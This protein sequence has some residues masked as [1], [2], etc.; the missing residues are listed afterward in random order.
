MVCLDLPSCYKYMTKQKETKKQTKK[1]V[2]VSSLGL[3]TLSWASNYAS[4]INCSVLFLLL[5][6]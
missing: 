3:I 5:K 4:S 6:V 2:T 1:T